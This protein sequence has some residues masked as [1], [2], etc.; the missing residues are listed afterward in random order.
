LSVK[1]LA[2]F[3]DQGHRE[4]VPIAESFGRSHGRLLQ[5]GG[6]SMRARSRMAAVE[7]T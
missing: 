6:S 5:D 1:R 3:G 2:V 7:I 4:E